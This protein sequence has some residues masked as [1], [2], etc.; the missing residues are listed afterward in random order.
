M[1]HEINELVKSISPE[2]I[3]HTV[4][5]ISPDEVVMR[6]SSNYNQIEATIRNYPHFKNKTL[7]I[8]RLL[9][10]R[11]HNRLKKLKVSRCYRL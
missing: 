4:K 6:I 2:E 11:C 5:N 10:V 1:I 7:R 3:I 9:K 8:S